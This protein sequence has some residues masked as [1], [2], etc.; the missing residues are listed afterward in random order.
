MKEIALSLLDKVQTLFDRRTDLSV[1]NARAAA[2]QTFYCDP[3]TIFLAFQL[4]NRSEANITINSINVR[5]GVRFQSKHFLPPQTFEG[6]T[7][8]G[9]PINLSGNESKEIRLFF[10][11]D[12]VAVKPNTLGWYA[13]AEL[14]GA[15]DVFFE[16]PYGYEQ[17]RSFEDIHSSHDD[18]VLPFSMELCTSR[19]NTSIEATAHLQS[20]EQFSHTE[21]TRK[22]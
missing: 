8:T 9:F 14:S 10:F 22:F 19:K 21:Q 17:R 6:I 15:S 20:F 1:D 18:P 7:S 2:L 11:V 12:T 5:L 3:G 13:K 4:T 16:L